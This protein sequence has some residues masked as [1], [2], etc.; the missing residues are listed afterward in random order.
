[1]LRGNDTR[2]HLRREVNARHDP[3]WGADAVDSLDS[4]RG[5]V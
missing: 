3:R 5:A 2:L 4:R 1:V